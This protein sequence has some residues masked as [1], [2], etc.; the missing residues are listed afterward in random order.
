[1]MMLDHREALCLNERTFA[2]V[3]VVNQMVSDLQT[4]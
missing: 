4:S 2:E 3:R 1:M